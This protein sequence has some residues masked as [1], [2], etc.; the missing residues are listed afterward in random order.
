MNELYSLKWKNHQV[1]LV[2]VFEEL[3][4]KE[5]FID[6]TLSCPGGR[7]FP[8]HRMVLSA[9]SPYFHSLFLDPALRVS[10]QPVVFLRDVKGDE[11]EA[12]LRFMYR[13]HIDVMHEDLGPLLQLAHVLQIKG[14]ATV[15]NED[16]TRTM[17][18]GDGATCEKRPCPDDGMWAARVKKRKSDSPVSSTSRVDDSHESGGESQGQG[19]RK[20]S[21]SP[22][23]VMP[24]GENQCDRDVQSTSVTN[25]DENN[26][27]AAED[28][29]ATNSGS[30]SGANS[31][32]TANNHETEESAEDSME[33]DYGDHPPE[34]SRW[35]KTE[36]ADIDDE[37]DDLDDDIEDVDDD[38][39]SGDEG[40]ALDGVD[41][42]PRADLASDVGENPGDV[43][44]S[45]TFVPS[46]PPPPP[47]CPPYPVNRGTRIGMEKKGVVSVVGTSPGRLYSG[48]FFPCAAKP[49][50]APRGGKLP[51]KSRA[52]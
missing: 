16:R 30:A 18:H 13:G 52:Y 31:T 33:F 3:W 6:V 37:E 28:G 39:P 5:A 10:Q 23:P 25:G 12:L 43:M 49:V 35:L 8:A 9:C 44:V 46:S 2:D 47:P 45:V 50:G 17:V 42:K 38:V 4:E 40:N 36:V 11:L 1:N 29:S 41:L 20:P 48:F 24:D 21:N 32:P 51:T 34:A 19:G 14:L 27:G 26:K 22:H 15:T 7:N